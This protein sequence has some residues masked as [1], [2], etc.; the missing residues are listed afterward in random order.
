VSGF[1]YPVD[2]RGNVSIERRKWPRLEL[3]LNVDFRAARPEDQASG[4]GVTKNVSAGGIYFC[5]S[6]WRQLECGTVLEVQISGFGQYDVGPI[7]RSLEGK[8]E[9]LRLDPPAEDEE[10]GGVAIRFEESPEFDT[11]RRTG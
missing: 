10:E 6:E 2:P 4:T 7:F 5:T 11:F 8:A 1:V 9:V 3:R